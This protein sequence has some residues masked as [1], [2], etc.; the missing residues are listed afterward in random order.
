MLVRFCKELTVDAGG[1]QNLRRD[2]KDKKEDKDKKEK[3][4]TGMRG[5]RGY[6]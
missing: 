4:L 2:K 3:K 6:L 1:F 5:I